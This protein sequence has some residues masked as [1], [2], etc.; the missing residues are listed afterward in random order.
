MCFITEGN[1][2]RVQDQSS[3]LTLPVHLESNPLY[4]HTE[5]LYD[6]IMHCDNLTSIK[7]ETTSNI[8]LRN[9]TAFGNRQLHNNEPFSPPPRSRDSTS[10]FVN[11][12]GPEDEYVDMSALTPQYSLEV[13]SPF[14]TPSNGKKHHH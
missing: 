11:K 13:Q 5:G 8:A 7:S 4:A 6:V 3:G 12:E 10:F 14:S 1:T 9:P 2:V